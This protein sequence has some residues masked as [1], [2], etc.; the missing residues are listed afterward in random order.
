MKC[1]RRQKEDCSWKAL[2][3]LKY[4]CMSY[5]F[6]PYYL[7][8]T[9]VFSLYM[10]EHSFVNVSFVPHNLSLEDKENTFKSREKRKKRKE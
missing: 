10:M 2:L 9:I 7:S 8:E 5:E 1:E 6:L 3:G 4:H